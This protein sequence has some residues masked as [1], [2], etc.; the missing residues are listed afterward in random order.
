MKKNNFINQKMRGKEIYRTQ[1]FANFDFF[2]EFL[3]RIP[4]KVDMKGYLE[5]YSEVPWRIGLFL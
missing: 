2:R 3:S 5:V 4:R 1:Y